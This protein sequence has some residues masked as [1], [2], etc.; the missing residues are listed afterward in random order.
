MRVNNMPLAYV[1]CDLGTFISLPRYDESIA[2]GIRGSVEESTNYFYACNH[3]SKPY[4]FIRYTGEMIHAIAE[5]L[6]KNR[7]SDDIF[8]FMSGTSSVEILDLLTAISSRYPDILPMGRAADII[9]ARR[10]YTY[11]GIGWNK[12]QLQVFEE[13]GS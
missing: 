2:W 9:D 5:D 8:C 12:K 6:I 3:N 13:I 11:D 1:F 10:D 7:N 4:K